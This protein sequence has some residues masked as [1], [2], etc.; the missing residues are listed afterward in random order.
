MGVHY[1]S[2]D[3][4]EECWQLLR[5]SMTSISFECLAYLPTYSQWLASQDWTDAYR[6][7]P[8]QPAADRPARRGP[9]LGAEEPQPPVRPRRA[10]RGLSGR[11]G[12]PDPPRAAHDRSPSVCSLA[13]QATEGWSDT[14]TRRGDR[15]RASSSCGRAGCEQFT[16]DARPARP[17]PVHRRRLRGLRRRPDRHRRRAST[18][19]SGSA[20]RRRPSR[21]WRRCTPKVAAATADPPTSTRSRSSG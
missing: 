1:I 18:R 17:G 11:A 3:Q 21:R 14:F 9:P 10:A 13:A 6:A 20:D 16:A 2:A 4:V 12:D 19:T 8:A 15:P 5:Q 7:A